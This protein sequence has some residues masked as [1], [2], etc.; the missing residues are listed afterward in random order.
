VIEVK[1]ALPTSSDEGNS[2]RK[3]I[4]IAMREPWRGIEEHDQAQHIVVAEAV[5]AQQLPQAHVAQRAGGGTIERDHH[6]RAVATLQRDRASQEVT[7][8]EEWRRIANTERHGE[9]SFRSYS[10][11]RAM[12]SGSGSPAR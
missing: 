1:D 11:A 8:G 7:H 9:P 4:Q 6:R 3:A 5:P 10:A 12:K 2:G